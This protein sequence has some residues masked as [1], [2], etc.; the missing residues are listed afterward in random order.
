MISYMTRMDFFTFYGT[1]LVFLTLIEVVIT[2]T[3]AKQHNIKAAQTID[4]WARVLFPTAF[5]RLTWAA[6]FV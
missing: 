2:M 5:A 1:V 4:L 6:F 3:L